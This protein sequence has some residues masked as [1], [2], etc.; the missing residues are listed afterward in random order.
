MPWYLKIIPIRALLGFF[1]P[2]TLVAYDAWI[3]GKTP[4]NTV[5]LGETAAN[6]LLMQFDPALEPTVE[7]YEEVAN[8]AI[9]ATIAAVEAPNKTSIEVAIIATAKAAYSALLATLT[10]EQVAGASTPDEV[11]AA[12]LVLANAINKGIA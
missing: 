2:K 1:I 9:Y 5:A 10:P 3:A 12:A 11:E 8:P 4:E 6:E 7:H